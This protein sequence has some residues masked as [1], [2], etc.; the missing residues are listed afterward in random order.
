M[1]RK[2]RVA[3]VT[4]ANKGI[5]F[6]V[7]RQLAREGVHVFLGARDEKAGEAAA[8]RLRAEGAR[9][10]RDN[11][12]TMIVGKAMVVRIWPVMRP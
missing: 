3:F 8:E 12:S 11:G 5:G 2:Q 4:G 7:A 6:E 1:N 10:K 9:T